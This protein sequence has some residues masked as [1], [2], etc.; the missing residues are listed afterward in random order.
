V[1]DQVIE[2]WRNPDDTWRWRWSGPDGSL[3]SNEAYLS[4]DEA[5]TAARVAYPGV[6]VRQDEPPEGAVLPSPRQKPR[7][8]T[9]LVAAA[10]WVA[11]FLL[12]RRRAS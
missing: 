1:R 9:R 4:R 11:L 7:P 10:V 8:R 5:V 2:L 6:P 12:G 3:T